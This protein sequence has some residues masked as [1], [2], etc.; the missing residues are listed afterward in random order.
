MDD[1]QRD[2]LKEV[3]TIAGG[4]TK[5]AERLGESQSQWWYWTNRSKK[6]PP[7]HVALKIETEF[8]IS[9]SRIRPDLYPPSE[10]EAVQ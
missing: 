6:G 9:R 1:S 4:Q 2:A 5:A 3:E 10:T 8:G 7:G